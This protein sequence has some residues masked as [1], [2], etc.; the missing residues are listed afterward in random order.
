M[1]LRLLPC[2]VSDFYARHVVIMNVQLK[3]YEFTRL[4]SNKAKLKHPNVT[5]LL[6]VCVYEQPHEWVSIALGRTAAYSSCLSHMWNDSHTHGWMFSSSKYLYS[7]PTYTS[8]PLQ[9]TTSPQ[10]RKAGVFNIPLKLYIF[11]W[12][13]RSFRAIMA[14]NK[15][16]WFS[17]S[18][19]LKIPIQKNA[20]L[21]VFF[22]FPPLQCLYYAE[23]CLGY[24]N[25][26]SSPS[27]CDIQA[28]T[29]PPHPM[30]F[31]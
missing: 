27:G 7:L 2:Y 15:Y 18:H 10:W 19:T 20:H 6:C 21:P 29:G 23:L 16:P 31:S 3:R 5:E 30:V 13:Q 28:Q 24:A 4:H 26:L 22:F 17:S 1:L 8:P 11:H 12:K 14:T 25:A 9:T